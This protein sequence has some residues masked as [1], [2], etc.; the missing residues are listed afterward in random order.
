MIF[1]IVAWS[2]SFPS[3]REKWLAGVALAAAALAVEDA[4]ERIRSRGVVGG[5]TAM[6]KVAPGW[7]ATGKY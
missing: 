6:L 5:I 7:W 2:W 1:D 3:W 4:P